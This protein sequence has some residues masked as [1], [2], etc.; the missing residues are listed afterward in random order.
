[1]PKIGKWD[2]GEITTDEGA[3]AVAYFVMNKN[4]VTARVQCALS[5]RLGQTLTDDDGHKWVVTDLANNSEGY[6]WATVAPL[7]SEQ[8][9]QVAAATAAPPPPPLPVTTTVSPEGGE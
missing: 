9:A 3:S 7:Q 8:A 6:S 2:Q 4:G 5:L 1:M